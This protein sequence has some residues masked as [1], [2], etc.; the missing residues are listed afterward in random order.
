[1]GARLHAQASSYPAGRLGHLLRLGQYLLRPNLYARRHRLGC[2]HE[3]TQRLTALDHYLLQR[4]LL[5]RHRRE[6]R[7]LA[8]Y[9]ACHHRKDR[10]RRRKRRYRR[11]TR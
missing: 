10:S 4:S 8:G 11:S 5:R 2:R 9:P 3:V 7:F 1:M 6:Q